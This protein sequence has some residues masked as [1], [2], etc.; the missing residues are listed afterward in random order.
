MTVAFLINE[1]TTYPGRDGWSPHDDFLAATE[2]GVR[3]WA[4]ILSHSHEVTVFM[5]GFEGEYGGATYVKREMYRKIGRKF[6]VTLNHKA[7]DMPVYD[8]T[9]YFTS[10]TDASVKDL[11]AFSAVVWPSYW[12]R[13]AIEVNNDQVEVIHYGY[14]PKTI[15]PDKKISKQCLYASAPTRGLADLVEIWPEVYKAHPDATLIVTYGADPPPGHDL[16][17]VMFMGEVDEETMDSLYRTSDFWVHPCSGGELFGVTAIK[18]QAAGCV[19]VY[20]PTMA[21]SETVKHGVACHDSAE[22]LSELI[23]IMDNEEEKQDIRDCLA[24]E[25][26]PTWESTAQDIERL[27]APVSPPRIEGE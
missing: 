13:E 16:P 3:R 15:Y 1:V 22:L 18:A 23:N 8:N 12:A 6:D 25:A 4:S 20:Y 17:G 7:L 10:E 24:I 27:I 11:S 21:L 5:N 19:P 9:Y 26:Y 2:D 14:D